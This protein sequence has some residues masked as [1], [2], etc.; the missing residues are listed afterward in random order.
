MNTTGILN[1]KTVTEIG[2]NWFA[3]QE[4]AW[5]CF[6]DVALAYVIPVICVFGLCEN[7]T[8]L[9]GLYNMNTGVGKS[10]RLYYALL[11]IFNLCNIVLFYLASGWLMIGLRFATQGRFF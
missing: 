6:H 2:V 1:A 5:G 9:Y 4:L 7:L 11:A 3:E 10:S 8:I